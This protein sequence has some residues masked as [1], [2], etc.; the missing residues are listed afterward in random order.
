MMCPLHLRR[1]PR[2]Y[3]HNFCLQHNSQNSVVAIASCKGGEEMQSFSPE[4]VTGQPLEGFHQGRWGRVWKKT[5]RI[6]HNSKLLKGKFPCGISGFCFFGWF[7]VL[8][9]FSW[10]PV[11]FGL[12]IKI[13]GLVRNRLNPGSADYYM[14]VTLVKD[15]NLQDYWMNETTLLAHLPQAINDGVYCHFFLLIFPLRTCI[16]Q[17]TSI[18]DVRISSFSHQIEGEL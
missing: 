17:N 15:L 18:T 4:G 11:V 8:V 13:V 7:L 6:C 2:N 10:G 14:C 3:I 5:D 1:L 9:C 12:V 16:P